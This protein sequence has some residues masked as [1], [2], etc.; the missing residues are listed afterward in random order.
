[1]KLVGGCLGSPD[2]GWELVGGLCALLTWP[3]IFTRPLHMA[4]LQRGGLAMVEHHIGLWGRGRRGTCRDPSPVPQSHYFC[5]LT[6][7]QPS[8]LA[9]I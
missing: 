6:L 9:Q 7:S 5:G 4:S 1:M 2:G 3:S 8:R